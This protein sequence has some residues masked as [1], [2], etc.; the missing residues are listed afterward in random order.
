MRKAIPND[1]I[2]SRALELLASSP[3]PGLEPGS[4]VGYTGVFDSGVGGISLL[5]ELTALM[6]HENFAFFGDSANAPYGDKPYDAVF[7]LSSRIAEAFVESGCKAVVI[8]CNTAT[9]TAADQLRA[10][11][12]QIPIVG[13]EPALK[14]AA[15]AGRDGS[16]LVMATEVTLKLDKFQRLL[17]EYGKGSD[18]IAV[19]C[20]G[21]ADRIEKGRLEDEDLV[22]LIDGLVGEYRGRVGSVV[23][24]C[25]HYLFVKDQIRRV[26]GDIPFYDGNMGTAMHL[27]QVLERLGLAR[28]SGAGVVRFYSSL[29]S[30]DEIELYKRF[31]SLPLDARSENA[32]TTPLMEN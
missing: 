26:L 23:L 5:R 9:S 28:S 18:V 12:P 24:G 4:L 6:P 15:S 2:D 13:I 20:T 31:F 17:N 8:A 21:L 3:L 7:G 32:R 16:I 27:K 30:P 11:Y 14:P 10:A 19:P 22:E 29:N 1:P 25:T